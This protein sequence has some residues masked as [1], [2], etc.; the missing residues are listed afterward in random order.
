MAFAGVSDIE[1]RW[2]KLSASEEATAAVLLDDASAALS[3]LVDVD[4]HDTEQ[5][6]ILKFVCCSMVIRKMSATKTDTYGVS[7]MS[8]T[9]GP[10]TQQMAYSNPTGDWYLTKFER[11]LLGVTSAYIGSIRPMMAGEHDV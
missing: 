1:A 10:Y 8:M 4:S 3:K 2:R 11:R 6:D 7:S 9:A 5:A